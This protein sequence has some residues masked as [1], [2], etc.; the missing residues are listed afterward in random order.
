MT[1]EF[2]SSVQDS[3][4][5]I[6]P[7]G[8]RIV[9]TTRHDCPADAAAVIDT[10]LGDDNDAA[11]RRDRRPSRYAAPSHA[12]VPQAAFG[13]SSPLHVARSGAAAGSCL[14][15]PS[16]CV[17][18]RARTG[19]CLPSLFHSFRRLPMASRMARLRP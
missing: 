19:S 6:R 17:R 18:S 7:V 12:A 2:G 3:G 4:F 13:V 14:H 16:S 5:G 1:D 8:E 10:G 11:A 15:T 9:L